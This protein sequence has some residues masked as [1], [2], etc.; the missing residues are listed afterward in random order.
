MQ[1]V[2]RGLVDLSDAYLIKSIVNLDTDDLS[3]FNGRLSVSIEP[4]MHSEAGWR[5]NR[6]LQCSAHLMHR[7]SRGM[8]TR[9]VKRVCPVIPL[10]SFPAFFL[11]LIQFGDLFSPPMSLL[12]ACVEGTGVLFQFPVDAQQGH[13]YS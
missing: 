8:D 2:N 4:E 12:A 5:T 3:Q 10:L 11:F 13:R 1:P 6:G 9:P 7:G